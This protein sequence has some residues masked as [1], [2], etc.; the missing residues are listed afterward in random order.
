MEEDALTLH[1]FRT[2][3]ANVIKEPAAIIWKM[4]WRN[5]GHCTF[6]AVK[7]SVCVG[8]EG[9]KSQKRNEIKGNVSWKEEKIGKLIYWCDL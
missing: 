9:E 7:E 4:T 5:G 3:G 2:R 1:F 8:G 6:N